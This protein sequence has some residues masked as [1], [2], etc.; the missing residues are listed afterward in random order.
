MRIGLRLYSK[1]MAIVACAVL[2]LICWACPLTLQ[3]QAPQ[4][5]Y[6]VT[7]AWGSGFQTSV[8]ITNTGSTPIQNWKLQFTL[9]YAISSIWNAQV[10]AQSENTYTII[11]DSWDISIP[12]GGS[13]NFGF[14]GSAYAGNAP[15]NP[16]NCLV[17]GEAV[18]STTCTTGSGT[19]P[20]G[21]PTGLTAADVTSSSVTLSWTAAAKGTNPITSYNVYEN[22]KLLTSSTTTSTKITGLTAST[23]YQFTVA[24]VDS[25]G[26][27]SS[28]SSAITVTTSGGSGNSGGGADGAFPS[29]FFAPYV[30]VTVY[31]TFNL[32]QS[33]PSAGPYFTMAF[34]VDG[35]GCSASWGGVVP[36]SQNWMLS[37]VQNLR[38][39]GGD[40]IVSFGGEAGSELAQTCST[41]AALQAQYQAVIDMYQLKRID[42][43]IEGAAEADTTSIGLRDEA[44]AA[45]QA[46]NPGLEVS[47]TLPV[48]P[49]GLTQ[50]G[51][52]VIQDA[53]SKGVKLKTVNVMAMDYGQPDSQMGQDA[54][55][56]G[57]ATAKQLQSLYPE[58]SS[59]QALAMVGVTP[60]IGVNDTQGETFSLNDAQLLLNWARSNGVGF[61]SMWSATRDSACV[62]GSTSAEPTCSGV[63]QQPFAFSEI[64]K[65]ID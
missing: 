23:T 35:G 3:A 15:Q 2:A 12:A 27:I 45:L 4:V 24:A 57:T 18:S 28:Q 16:A 63:S 21:A 59:S 53:I 5:A 31:P 26:V 52:N 33:A 1:Y 44:I 19:V 58:L 50:D 54:I 34:I 49:T 30:D 48:L 22:G 65:Q 7:S 32:T 25:A 37:D 8:T 39:G 42:F 46:A 6:T 55:N 29:H 14:I 56:A 13:V 43:D 60:M 47:F 40:V 64:F 10:A 41:E 17:N 9:P 38:A 11:G 20:P 61:L 51:L 62:D 36:L